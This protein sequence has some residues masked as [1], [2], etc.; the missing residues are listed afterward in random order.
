MTVKE[1]RL[2]MFGFQTFTKFSEA[3]LKNGLTVDVVDN[4]VKGNLKQMFNLSFLF[5]FL[6]LT[7][8]ANGNIQL[9]SIK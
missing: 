4:I 8:T 7:I 6:T 9:F 1:E 5:I 3:N 2:T